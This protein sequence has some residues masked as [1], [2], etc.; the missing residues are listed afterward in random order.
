MGR[1][2]EAVE[3]AKTVL[4]VA[5]LAWSAVE[6]LH[7]HQHKNPNSQFPGEETRALSDEELI[8]LRSENKRL[9][10]LLE[11]NLKLLQNLSSSPCFDNDCPPD[12][13]ERIV[14][15]VD[16][17]KFLTRLQTLRDGSANGKANE[18]PFK[19]PTGADLEAA[20]ILINVDQEEPSWWV[21]VTDAM[22]NGTE[23]ERSEIDNESYVVVCEEHVVDGVANFLARCIVSN[24]KLQKLT[25][26]Q[27]QKTLTKSLGG[28]DKIEKMLT[29]WHAGKLFCALTTWGLALA[30]LYQSR[31]VLKLA[32]QGVHHTSK[33]V[34]KAI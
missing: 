31:A 22:V 20:E 1:A 17:E 3:V 24:P 28:I 2:H 23:E 19:E 6:H 32:A 16:S 27:L 30:G 4:E 11:Q 25:P 15:A 21:W 18:F 9:T 34:L 13:Y 26:E 7:H 14:A 29:I 8:D 12:L 5:E 10:E 33:L